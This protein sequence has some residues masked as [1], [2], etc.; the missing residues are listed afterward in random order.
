[1]STQWT[2]DQQIAIETIG[3]D[4]LVSAAA[5]SGKTAV[6]VERIIRKIIDKHINIDE[7][8]VVTFTNAS[9]KEMKER[10]HNRIIHELKQDP[11]NTHLQRQLNKIHLAEIST[12]HRFCLNLI[13]R[14]YYTIDLDPTFRTGNDE[15]MVL[16]L[17]QAID[18][19]LEEAY[20]HL[21]H[22]QLKL[23]MHMTSERS[24][25]KLRNL[26]VK[27]YYVAIANSNPEQWLA[28]LSEPYRTAHSEDENFKRL[29]AFIGEQA[30]HAQA[31]IK[32]AEDNCVI[33]TF[34]KTLVYLQEIYD[35][36]T[37]SESI[38]DKFSQLQSIKI[39]TKPRVS[40]K[41][42][43][44]AKVLNDA[45]SDDLKTVK[46]IVKNMQSMMY[47]SPQEMAEDLNAM[48]GEVKAL[49][50]LTALVID[51]FST[52]KRER[53]VIDFNDYEHFALE[54]LFKDNQPTEIA[55][56]LRNQYHEI[57][58]DEYQDT[59]SVQ[60]SII[61][62]IKQH[63]TS[64]G[65]LFMVGDVKQS[66]YKFRQA[67]PELFLQKYADFKANNTGKVVELSKNFRSRQS[68]I[69]DTNAIFER[70]MD[71]TVGD[72][73]YNEEQK[74][75]YGAPYDEAA[76]TTECHIINKEHIEIENPESHFI[77]QKIKHIIEHEQ[78]YDSKTKTYR[79]ATYKDIA[80]L[81]RSFSNA[82]SHMQVLKAYQIPFHVSSRE[83]YFKTDEIDTILSFLRVIDNPLQDIPLAGVLRSII[84]QFTSEELAEIRNSDTSI[85]LYQNLL[86]YQMNGKQEN[87]RYKVKQVIS[88]M[89]DYRSK[90]QS[91]SVSSLLKYIY[92]DTHFVDKYALLAGGIQRTA[93]L[94]KLLNLADNFEQSSYRGV[95]QFIRYIDNMLEH[96]KDFGE[97]NVISDEADVVRMMTVHASKGLEFPF[98]IYSAL[99]KKFN[100][101]DVS[102]DVLVDQHLGLSLDYFDMAEQISF[103]VMLSGIFKHQIKLSQISEEL[104]L[105]Y[106][107]F[108]R[109]REKLILLGT[110]KNRDALEKFMHVAFDE[111]LDSFYRMQATTPLQFIL[112]AIMQPG[113]SINSIQLNIVESIDA[114]VSEEENDEHH[115]I[116]EINWLTQ[117]ANYQYPYSNEF[118]LPT[119]ESVSD[120]KKAEADD[121]IT[122][123]TYVNEYRLGKKDFDRPEFMS[124]VKKTAQEKGTLMHLVMQHLPLKK[125]TTDE[126][127]LFLNELVERKLI[128]VEDIQDINIQHI[129]KFMESPIFSK[130]MQADEIYHELP[131]VIGKQYLTDA[132]PEQ[133]I[134]GMIDCVFKYNNQ[135]Y[136]LDYKTDKINLR[137][138]RDIEATLNVM[139]EKYA[140]QM[141]YYQRALE[142][143]LGSNV[144][145]YLYFFEG[146]LVEVKQ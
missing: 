104:R 54:I 131:F 1:M 26:L 45:I 58:V 27:L 74:L 124:E 47:A 91:L 97:V 62:A 76:Q 37:L 50:D 146:G 100:L 101:R 81:E 105:M 82:V 83:G 75:Y 55:L 30:R 127:K 34:D 17:M 6:L 49:T 89:N 4:T 79:N 40:T 52:L 123:W 25:D 110:I 119:K 112:P 73:D 88:D 133:L 65:N 51:R 21:S 66:I 28:S 115:S 35:S 36:L 38:D 125:M 113:Q 137:L 31:L 143:V 70:I 94:K 39:G 48:Y 44:D 139:A 108:T 85:Y 7:L 95:F 67:E 120:I 10:I 3:Q 90:Y 12:L 142:T 138:G 71:N 140:I 116:S 46:S 144:K 145:A 56:N 63:P 93:N 33:E 103:P 78:V 117:L 19:V 18:D 22:D 20:H 41:D 107:A 129:A 136:L 132:H 42:D 128:S 5:G 96:K 68:V 72:I 118:S 87:L 53:K 122:T 64:E 69:N 23:V 77:A 13:E 99:N 114:N 11:A 102:A 60:E 134:Q 92:Q 8:L 61:Q 98:V 86:Q 57:L 121:E 141:K 32:R 24:D 15:E 135:Y 84:Y 130:M 109:A 111:K 106:V 43:I 9:A 126:L 29:N 59:N 2:E 14:Y 80:I 16:L